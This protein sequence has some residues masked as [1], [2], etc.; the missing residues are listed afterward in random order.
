[1]V[2]IVAL[3]IAVLLSFFT[4]AC[5]QETETAPDV[6]A[7]VDAAVAATVEA[8]S[9][10]PQSTPAQT[11]LGQAIPTQIPTVAA[12][13][14]SMPTATPVPTDTLAPTPTAT[15]TPTPFP[16]PAPTPTPTPDPTLMA[17]LVSLMTQPTQTST[18]IV[19]LVPAATLT[20]NAT[21]TPTRW[22]TA[23]P[24]PTPVPFDIKEANCQHEDLTTEMSWHDFSLTESEGPYR[25]EPWGIREW[26]RTDWWTDDGYRIRCITNIFNSVE[27][28]QWSLNY[29]TALERVWGQE[30]LLEHRQVFAPISGDDTLA[31]EIEVGRRF[32]VAGQEATTHVYVAK[33]AM[34]RRG[35]I[36][37][38]LE[39]G[40]TL[41]EVCPNNPI[42][43]SY[44]PDA[45][46]NENWQPVTDIAS[47]VDERLLAELA[48]VNR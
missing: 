22:P 11:N 32:T 30:G 41:K 31:I 40:S 47:R 24:T 9:A 45:F 6:G 7:T 38:I 29:S 46:F 28:A 25:Y 13:P 17:Y 4:I 20:P 2:K 44:A 35:N 23:T 5:S 12:I 19:T 36:V 37:V 10:A 8:Q 18:P 34:F 42:L 16:A 15:T 48:R 1:M 27:D 14:T 43:C 21:P 26:Y 39:Y 33:F 3:A